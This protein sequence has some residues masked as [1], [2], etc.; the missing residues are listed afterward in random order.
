M[1]KRLIIGGAIALG[2]LLVVGAVFTMSTWGDVNRV[3]IDREDPVTQQPVEETPEEEP[4][5]DPGQEVGI[6]EGMEVF[7]LVGSDSRD[8]LERRRRL[9]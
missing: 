5:T 8:D 9:R 1:K 7:L 6:S 3:T 2:L 4:D